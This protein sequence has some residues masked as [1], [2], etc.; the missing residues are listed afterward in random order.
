MS[1]II[2]IASEI[3]IEKYLRKFEGKPVSKQDYVDW[4]RRI[5]DIANRGINPLSIVEA[6]ENSGQISTDEAALLFWGFE[7]GT[8]SKDFVAAFEMDGETAKAP[9]EL[10][11]E[12][13]Y[14]AKSFFEVNPNHKDRYNFVSNARKIEG[15]RYN[16]NDIFVKLKCSDTDAIELACLLSPKMVKEVRRINGGFTLLLEY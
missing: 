12:R 16:D 6:L 15:M 14:T 10:A 5:R 1:R 7:N 13:L 8:N 3:N 4:I 11:S 9:R 2:E